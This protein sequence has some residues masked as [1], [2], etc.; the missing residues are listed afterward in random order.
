MRT[1]TPPLLP[2]LRSQ[3][4]ADLLTA[5]LLHPERE[6]TLTELGKLADA[7]LSTVRREIDRFVEVGLVSERQVGRSRLV[8]TVAEHPYSAAL[9]E[10]ITRAFGPSAIVGEEFARLPG[11]PAV[12]IFGSWAARYGGVPGPSPNDVDVLVVGAAKRADIYAAAERCE[13]RLHQMPVNPV[14]SSLERWYADA[15]ALIREIKVSP[16][17]WVVGDEPPPRKK[18]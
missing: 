17:L 11:D 12:A 7:P 9:T 8:T 15:D 6:Y 14:L 13:E 18:A 2:I 1:I 16:L 4:Q 10:L 3:V 5:L